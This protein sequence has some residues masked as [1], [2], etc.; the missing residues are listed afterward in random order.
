M[1]TQSDFG[2]AVIG[3]LLIA[4]IFI[5]ATIFQSFEIYY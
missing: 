5:L 2:N 1:K 3:F 4:I